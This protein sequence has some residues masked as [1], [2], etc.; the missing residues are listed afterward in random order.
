[1]ALNKKV[2]VIGGTGFLGKHLINHFKKIYQVTSLSRIRRHNTFRDNGIL[3]KYCNLENKYDSKEFFL[4][5][6]F[7]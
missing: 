2:L 6:H 4:K 5:N 1:M 7:D 3:Y